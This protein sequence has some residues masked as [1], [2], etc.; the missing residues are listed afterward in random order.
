MFLHNIPTEKELRIFETV[1][2]QSIRRMKEG[3][4]RNETN[5]ITDGQTEAPPELHS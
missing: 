4:V 1:L 2:Q 5:N 3:R